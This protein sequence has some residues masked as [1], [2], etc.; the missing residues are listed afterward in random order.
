LVKKKQENQ[1][2]KDYHR[3]APDAVRR[4]DTI[5]TA[6][7]DPTPAPHT[8]KMPKTPVLKP[9]ASLR[10][11]SRRTEWCGGLTGKK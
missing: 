1:R 9:A 11:P 3:A 2:F 4:I 5:P 6:A 10:L 8:L 7:F